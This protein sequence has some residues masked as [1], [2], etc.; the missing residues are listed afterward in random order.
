MIDCTPK[1]T[2]D[3]VFSSSESKTM[4]YSILEQ[5][6]PFPKNGVCGL[7]F[8]GVFGSGKTTYAEIFCKEFDFILCGETDHAQIE[9]VDCAKTRDLSKEMTRLDNHSKWRTISSSNQVYF[10]FDEVDCLTKKD[11]MLLKTFMNKSNIVCILTTNYIDFI[12]YGVRDRCYE[13]NFNAANNSDYL[14]RLKQ[15]IADNNLKPPSD[16]F[17]L[18]LVKE[19]NGSWRKLANY[20]SFHCE[21]KRNL[22]VVATAQKFEK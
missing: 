13:I 22:S 16:K 19:S 3:M 6:M 4:I 1:S 5:K 14:P 20:F 7:L 21:Q 10:I 15:I 9:Y 11:Q 18:D 12:D 2:K 8:Y 17:L